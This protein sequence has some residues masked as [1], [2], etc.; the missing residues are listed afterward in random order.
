[1]YHLSRNTYCILKLTMLRIAKII[2]R[3]LK[4]IGNSWKKNRFQGGREQNKESGYK[5]TLG[6]ATMYYVNK[7]SRTGRSARTGAC[8]KC[9]LLSGGFICLSLTTS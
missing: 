2:W 8:V 1:M 5:H 9:I 4:D 3:T 7:A 6:S